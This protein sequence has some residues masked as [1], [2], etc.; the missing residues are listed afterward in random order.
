M[1]ELF[2]LR[3]VAM[4]WGTSK[5]G[6]TPVNEAPPGGRMKPPRAPGIIGRG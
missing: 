6:H 1:A 4:L 3:A 5:T 2:A